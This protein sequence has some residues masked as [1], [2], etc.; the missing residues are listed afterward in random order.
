[1]IFL[2]FSGSPWATL[3]EGGAPSGRCG[4]QVILLEFEKREISENNL[5]QQPPDSHE[6]ANRVESARISFVL[7]TECLPRSPQF[8]QRTPLI[9]LVIDY[10]VTRRR[11]ARCCVAAGSAAR[12]GVLGGKGVFCYSG[13]RSRG[14]DDPFP[15]FPSLPSLPFLLFPS[16][17]S[18]PSL[19]A[20]A[21][22]PDLRQ[23]HFIY[24]K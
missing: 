18:L 15:P 5:L 8:L 23:G 12:G 10:W 9:L 4:L 20:S 1:M 16:F 14:L 3:G 6:S 24:I 13:S 22:R 21:F 19:S 17:P 7:R 2:G 11:P